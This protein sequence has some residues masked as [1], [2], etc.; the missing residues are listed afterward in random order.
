MDIAASAITPT[1]IS[2][3]LLK[4]NL[5]LLAIVLGLLNDAAMAQ[6]TYFASPPTVE[7]LQTALHKQQP[8]DAAL[9]GPRIQARGIMPKSEVE[10]S[11]PAIA[12]PVSF[13]VG[14]ARI[15]EDLMQFVDP[16]AE[17]LAR[18][19][20]L[21]LRVEGHTDASGDAW[22]NM[23]LSWERA[24]AIYK[25]LVQRYGV[26]PA[27]LTPVGKGDTE[28]MPGTEPTAGRNRRVQFRVLG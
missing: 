10:E 2:M 13:G 27:R 18:D 21:R 15:S 19:T 28:P 23:V 24:F 7:Q 25:T 22:G 4:L 3:N 5:T 17:L 20:S 12:I 26:D 8:Q 14:S 11:S 16:I 9:N 6:V 1:E